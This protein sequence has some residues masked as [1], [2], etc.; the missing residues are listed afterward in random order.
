MAKVARSKRRSVSQRSFQSFA[1]KRSL[2]ERSLLRLEWLETRRLLAT[3]TVT[4]NLDDGSAGTLRSVVAAAAAGDTIDFAAGISQINLT[5]GQIEIS[6]NLT[7]QGPGASQLTVDQT[8]TV[9]ALFQ[10]DTVDANDN[11]VA[12]S[13]SGLSLGGIVT[14]NGSLAYSNAGDLTIASSISGPGELTVTDAGNMTV[15]P[16]VNL[17][18]GNGLTLYATGNLTVDDGATLNSY[19]STLTLGADI[20]ANGTGYGDGSSGTLTVGDSAQNA[21]KVDV[22]GASITLR[23]AQESIGTNATVGSS[24]PTTTTF[25]S[26]SN[27]PAGL[28]VDASGNVYVADSGNNTISVVSPSGH[29]ST[30]VPVSAGLNNPSAIA[31]DASGNLYVADVGSNTIYEISST[32]ITS[33]LNSGSQVT[34]LTPFVRIGL[35]NFRFD[36]GL[37]VDNAG[38]LYLTID[39]NTITEITPGPG[40]PSVIP[41]FVT[42][43]NFAE[44]LTTGPGG[45]IYVA[46]SSGLD[47]LQVTPGGSVSTYANLNVNG[48]PG[49]GEYPSSLAFDSSGNMYVLGEDE[50]LG[51]VTVDELLKDAP[52]NIGFQVLVPG[53]SSSTSIAVDGAGNVYVPTDVDGIV[54]I[55]P[56]FVATT[57]ITIQSSVESR[58]MLI[59]GTSNDSGFDGINLTNAE[60]AR[61][62]EGAANYP[63]APPFGNAPPDTI[64]FGD[65]AQTGDIT[66]ADA[67]LPAVNAGAN[68]AALESTSGGA[69][70]VL[71]NES[72]TAPAIQVGANGGGVALTSGTGGIVEASTN[73]N[74]VPDISNAA[75]H[76]N[77]A[78]DGDWGVKLISGAAIGS[79][80]QPLQVN[81]PDGLD[82][83]SATGTTIGGVSAVNYFTANNSMS[84][85][86]SITNDGLDNPSIYGTGLEIDGISQ[87]GSGQVTVANTGEVT[88]ATA[89]TSSG[90]GA[91]SVTATGEIDLNA[92]ITVP[93]VTATATGSN[94]ALNVNANIAAENGLTLYATGNLTVSGGVTL[95]SYASTLTLG[96]D[97][98]PDGSGDT[99]S[100][101]TLTLGDN[102]NN[103][104]DI[105]GAS[106]TLRGA[107]ENILPN[108][109]VGNALSPIQPFTDGLLFPEALTADADGN[110]YVVTALS[111]IS[112]VT[113]AGTVSTVTSFTA[114]SGLAVDANGNLYASTY[115]TIQKVTPSGSVSTFVT[116]LN[117]AQGLAVDPC[118]NL[119]VADE[120]GNEILKITPSGSISILASSGLDAPQSLVYHAGDLYVTNQGNTT[121]AKVDISSGN[122]S[123][124][125]NATFP[126]QIPNGGLAVDG[127]GNLYVSDPANQRVA[128]VTSS[129]VS[130]FANVTLG[131][132]SLYALTFAGGNLYATDADETVYKIT[133]PNQASPFA[134]DS[135]PTALISGESAAV[136]ANGNVYVTAS[137]TVAKI[138]PSGDVSTFATGLDGVN[139]LTFDGSGNLYASSY[140]SNTI[141]KIDSSGEVVST[142]PIT[143]A[144]G[145]GG[146]AYDRLDGN[147]YLVASTGV[148]QF[149]VYRVDPTTGVAQSFLAGDV[150]NSD[151]VAV[152]TDATGMIYA[153]FSDS[154]NNIDI[155][156]LTP[157][158]AV[159]ATFVAPALLTYGGGPYGLAVDAAGDMFMSGDGASGL[160]YEITPA[161]VATQIGNNAIIWNSGLAL[162]SAGNLYVADGYVAPDVFKF[163][164]PFSPTTQITIAS[165]VES[166]PML[167]GGTDKVSGFGGVNLTNA[168]L[169]RLF[170][171]GT[172]LFA[173]LQASGTLT[174]GDADQSGDITFSNAVAGYGYPSPTT[175]HMAAIQSTTSQ[176][177][178]LLD[179]GSGSAPAINA[180]GDEIDLTAGKGGILEANSNALDTADLSDAAGEVLVSGG[181]VGSS[182]QPVQ[183]ACG[184]LGPADQPFNTNAPYLEVDT[185]ANNNDQYLSVVGGVVDPY[186]PTANGNASPEGPSS[187]AAGTGTIH[188]ESGTF[189]IFGGSDS[190]IAVD[191]GAT[192]M[193]NGTIAGNLTNSGTIAVGPGTALSVSGDYTQTA[194][195]TV[196]LGIDAP[197]A[198]AGTDYGQLAVTGTAYL[199]GALTATTVAPFTSALG[200]TYQAIAAG[201]ISGSFSSVPAGFPDGDTGVTSYAGSAVTLDDALAP[202][203]TIS[204]NLA[205]V[206]PGQ[207]ETLTLHVD[208]TVAADQSAGF[209]YTI[210]WGDGTT[211]MIGPA[212]TGTQVSHTYQ[213]D[214][215]YT[216]TITATSQPGEYSVAATQT[217]QVNTLAVEGN[218]LAV[219]DAAANDM[220]SFAPDPNTPGNVLISLNNS[221]LGSFAVAGRILAY[222]LG[223]SDTFNVTATGAGGI[224]LTGEGSPNTYSITFGNLAGTVTVVGN[225]AADADTLDVYATVGNDTVDKTEQQVV[226]MLSGYNN[227]I[228]N[229]SGIAHKT[230]QL[231]PG[232]DTVNDP[233]SDTTILG[234]PGQDTI[235]ITATS[236]NG[237][238]VNSGQGSD[239]VTVD[240]GAIAA[241]VNI[242]QPSSTSTNTLTVVAPPTSS[243]IDVTSTQVTSGTQAI[244]YPTTISNV[245]V[246]TGASSASVSVASTSAAGVTVQNQGGTTNT[247]VTLGS[248]AGPVNVTGT[249]STSVAVSAPSGNNTIA[250]SSSG[251]QSGTQTV[252][253]STPVTT[254]TVDTGSGNNNVSVSNLGTTVQNLAVNTG[255]GT[256]AVTVNNVG[257]SVSSVAVNGGSGTTS[258]TLN[259]VGSSAPPIAVSGG[260]GTTQLQVVG[261]PPPQV[262]TTQNVQIATVTV[263]TS[264][265]PNG[266]L[267]GQ[268]VT[269]TA[270]VGT[271]ITGAGTPTGS[272]QFVVDG[273]N[274][275]PVETLSGGAAS[276]SLAALT[277][278]PHTI[279]AQ[280][281]SNSSS[282]LNSASDPNFTASVGVANSIYV[283]N[284]TASGA[285][286]ISGN[287]AIKLPAGSD[288]FVDSSSSSAIQASGNATV[289]ASGVLVVGGI[290]KSGKAQA[291]ATG[292]P[293]A[294]GDPFATLPAPQTSGLT[295]YGSL[296]LSGNSTQTIKPGIYTQIAVSGNARLTMNAGTYIIEGGGF[297][298]SGNAGV[299]GSGV[300]IVNAGSKYPTTG[301]SYGYVN[302]SGGGTISLT[303]ET[304]GAEAG[305][306]VYQPKDNTQAL[307]F[308]GGAMAGM[309][310][311][312]YAASAAASISGNAALN[313]PMV[314]GTLT[315][316]GNSVFND[317]ASTPTASSGTVFSPDQI[318][319][320]YGLNN[321]SADGSGQT[322]AIVDA[323]DDPAI[324]DSLDTFDSQF[325]LTASGPSLYQQ[326]GPASSFLT[327]VNQS[328]QAGT[329]PAVDPAGAGG[330]NWEVEEALDVEWAHAAAPGARI[331]LVEANSQ[332][333]GDLMA[334]VATA[335]DLPGVSVVSMSWGFEEGQSVLAA[336]E[337]LYDGYLTTPAGHQ[338]VTFVA[339]TGDYGAAVPEYPAMSPNVVAVGGTSLTLNGDN[340]YQSETGWGSLDT[341]SG[342]FYGA[343]GG[344]SQF[345]PEPAYQQG[346]QTIGNRTTPDV[347]FVADP[348]TG[349][350]VADTYNLDAS[351]P[352]EVVG[353]TSLSAPAWAG[354][355]AVA[356]QMRVASGGATLGSDTTNEAQQALYSVPT[357]DY[358]DITTGSN[359]YLAGAGYD[360]VTGLGTPVAD[361][362]VP[363][364]AAYTAADTILVASSPLTA[365]GAVLSGNIGNGTTEAALSVANALPI[366]AAELVTPGM[367]V[368]QPEG[369][370][371]ID[372]DSAAPSTALTP[373]LSQ[374]ER[375]VVVPPVINLPSLVTSVADLSAPLTVATATGQDDM[376]QA[377]A[378]A[379]FLDTLR[380]GVSASADD[381]LAPARS[382]I[383]PAAGRVQEALEAVFGQ[384]FK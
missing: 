293:A 29:V 124:V 191:S 364:L 135:G 227:E 261:T 213:A 267:Y 292:T 127:S 152:A 148:N 77:F 143:G 85:G 306:L 228:I 350:W 130:T 347:S 271:N 195:G 353:G 33:F 193:G 198:T 290:A 61:F 87:T 95:N 8:T 223:G 235:N 181:P 220:F 132:G 238:T 169:A 211:Q 138:T 262:S 332:S 282:F 162:D 27:N 57:Q 153:A 263:V 219:G 150:V 337:A 248:L 365:A 258:V 146:I 1:R 308:N 119:Y 247:A 62:F 123:T 285:L 284:R 359:G 342:I 92:P 305:I 383:A 189:A 298:V 55:K 336:D 190:N 154:N 30:L 278:G 4:S 66:F 370:G 6:K 11:A 23:G 145:P 98:N 96:A 304:T 20:N 291:A 105:Y 90:S 46:N 222:G 100:T 313:L 161:G 172:T 64:T 206:V 331:V 209:T 281:L 48:G 316:S 52:S 289:S 91:L 58:H 244:N 338:G 88:V 275:G 318:R 203:L 43:L 173:P 84:G 330:D 69:Q 381:M 179:N 340:S 7:I 125:P 167:I 241:P 89:I 320:A 51:N 45:D 184:P 245:T 111:D 296:S 16:N 157:S 72:G 357:S 18:V 133:A 137:G 255:S 107:H 5:Q 81:A 204:P 202:A 361:K 266:S 60:L 360:L 68:L 354:L 10:V 114:G 76:V 343:G 186:S 136:D 26:T 378:D 239:A 234:G 40:G 147:F 182:S 274:Y 327:V 75:P 97:V 294:T 297:T 333:I 230:I 279:V 117:N 199:A 170:V 270:A 99:A 17:S 205:T 65:S 183:V 363:D 120:G 208:D 74:Q 126:G 80:A 71:D 86:I 257:T 243:S 32:E 280:Y 321:L 215:S 164:P 113:P 13:I 37:A 334:S 329:L 109:T 345:E 356:N 25:A 268:N 317:V 326:Y 12:V 19:A 325:G 78:F 368:G 233:G 14:D 249:G 324:F 159:L 286:T 118:G 221:S 346:V 180:N 322:I 312:V 375:Q 260:T 94:V 41:D 163:T 73:T 134:F 187:L 303:P 362:L 216:A 310:G 106:I 287:A 283:L 264:D 175:V 341:A 53:N 103:A 382:A 129:G 54:Q 367:S 139:G 366:F 144:T 372:V 22:Y 178:I 225:S 351:N 197:G 344:V 174:F 256:T 24:G 15:N 115:N 299:T 79:A 349:A 226:W 188:F 242:V 3:D 47:I 207:T 156:K 158:G 28:A 348:N 384:L 151:V 141:S 39:G 379:G 254:L 59:G 21:S 49:D 214:G 63:L 339:S 251:V 307:T 374:W 168:E 104:T 246:A 56:P 177:A 165:S 358:H 102:T 101:G 319:T 352:W 35:D 371:L 128:E 67:T 212:S 273:K 38:D 9:A 82:T 253:V 122:V 42:G 295:N 201:A 70:I 210:E 240:L 288:V 328:G 2:Y 250:V 140:T 272:V 110:L 355:I 335:A 323:Y 171:E 277:A 166:R 200:N 192:L 302:L 218:N 83:T 108:A 196:A 31:F 311:A 93:S 149:G 276:L 36:G 176:G 315:L 309:S 314:V 269:F 231:G 300:L 376:S 224:T 377:F 34:S 116:G 380:P 265:H 373:A 369:A 229:Y 232:Q 112:K 301:G 155:I 131:F 121:I 252:N 142:T 194:S 236:G 185:T 44:G 237:V 217:I 50:V 160:L 259:N